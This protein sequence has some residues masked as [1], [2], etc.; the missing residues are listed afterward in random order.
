MSTP[1][2][3]PSDG[4]RWVV[5]QPHGEDAGEPCPDCGQPIRRVWGYVVDHGE[6]ISSY[7]VTWVPGQSKH[8]VGYDLIFGRWDSEATGQN[9][10]AISL[11]MLNIDGDNSLKFVNAAGRIASDPRL[12][13]QA[14]TFREAVASPRAADILVL[15][16]AIYRTEPR[17]DEVRKWGLAG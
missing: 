16:N 13:S 11:D 5:V 2:D 14:L 12:F 15:A 9:R 7:F 3:A 8:K 6:I 17:L 10:V 1:P 4:P